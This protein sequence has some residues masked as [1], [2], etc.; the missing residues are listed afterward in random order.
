MIKKLEQGFIKSK[1]SFLDYHKSFYCLLCDQKA[2]LLIDLEMRK[3]SVDSRNC[4]SKLRDNKEYL[5]ALNIDLINYLEDMQAHLDCAYYEEHF[6]FP[7]LFKYEE[8]F[9]SE[10]LKC[11][12]KFDPENN[13]VDKS[14]MNLC[15]TL[16][17]G[18][19]SEHFEGT[20]SFLKKALDYYDGIVEEINHKNKE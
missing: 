13:E 17:I 16:K 9:K 8:Q 6:D 20:L 14:C 18:G 3:I 10:A 7:F 12:N 1:K 5:K 4:V 15:G 19:I 2:H 11:L